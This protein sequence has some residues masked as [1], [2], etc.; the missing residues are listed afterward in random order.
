[1]KRIEHRK[2][3][4]ARQTARDGTSQDFRD[5]ETSAVRTTVSFCKVALAVGTSRHLV[6]ISAGRPHVSTGI[7]G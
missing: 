2:D 6:G 7:A 3:Q 1:M 5:D 4:K